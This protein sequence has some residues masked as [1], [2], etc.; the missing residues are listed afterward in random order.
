MDRTTHD[1]FRYV[2]SAIAMITRSEQR[3]ASAEYLNSLSQDE[4]FRRFEITRTARIDGLDCIGVPVYSCA[5][6][7]ARVI[8][9]SAGKS[10][11]ARMARAGAVAEAIEFATF[12]KPVGRFWVTGFGGDLQL[13][14]CLDSAWTSETPIAI[15]FVTS[16]SGERWLL[17]SDLIWLT[18][19][20]GKEQHFMRSSNGQALGATFED[21]FCQ[22][23]CECVE[24]DQ[25][26]LRRISLK[27]LGIYPPVVDLQHGDIPQSIRLL[28]LKCVEASLKLHLFFC[29]CDIPIPVY[30]AILFDPT[31]YASFSGWGA[32]VRN[33][34]AAE[35]AIL[36]AIQSRAVYIAGARDDIE[37]RK[38]TAIQESDVRSMIAAI[39]A[40]PKIKWM[41]GFEPELSTEMELQWVLAALSAWR[42]KIYFKHI[43]LGDMHCVKSIILGLEQPMH[44]NWRPMRWDKLYE[45]HLRRAEPL[46][47]TS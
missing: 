2:R 5:R 19:R 9:V 8:S 10:L 37:R 4:L 1:G 7:E 33:E 32:G 39:E 41:A 38:F 46:S 44:D 24:R 12:E 22:G 36:E 43:D 30:W 27:K 6:P 45:D 26:T 17:P 40:Q 15:E 35:R 23:L 18:K 47:A 21:A 16:L 42:D 25:L 20:E 3:R 34:P 11:D 13:P 31:G 29:T 14:T 28:R